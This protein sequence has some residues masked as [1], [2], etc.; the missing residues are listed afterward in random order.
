MTNYIPTLSQVGP[1]DHKKKYNIRLVSIL[2]TTDTLINK[3]YEELIKYIL[4]L[5][6]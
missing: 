3:I 2:S 4:I 5:K 1:L 6:Y